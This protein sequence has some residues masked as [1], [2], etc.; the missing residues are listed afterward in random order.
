MLKR[1][2]AAG[3]ISALGPL[4]LQRAW[5]ADKLVIGV[6]YVG[7]RDDY[8]DNQAQAQAAAQIK[9]MPGVVVVE[10]EKVPES[11]DVQET[12]GSMIEQ[13]GATLLFPTSFRDFDPHIL[14]MAEK[15]SNIR[16]AP[17]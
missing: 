16:I 7:P 5:A 13:D 11:T 15:D 2:G 4:S 10:Q 17:C 14:R 9:K 12:M 3:A 8:G 1:L 6:I